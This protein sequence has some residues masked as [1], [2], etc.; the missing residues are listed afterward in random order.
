MK[1]K[2]V[3]LIFNLFLITLLLIMGTAVSRMIYSS[4]SALYFQR[5]R[6]CAF[7]LAEAG[8]DYGK[9]R[10]AKDPSFTTPP[11]R[12]ALGEGYFVVEKAKDKPLL[13]SG[14]FHSARVIIEYDNAVHHYSNL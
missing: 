12:Q 2:G 8:V 5:D 7:Y 11:L 10:L 13:S 3:A 4:V 1:N 14:N 6:L 9:T